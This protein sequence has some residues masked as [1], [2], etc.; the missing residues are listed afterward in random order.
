ME[1]QFNVASD[2]YLAGR[3][4]D[5]ENFTAEVYYV[6]AEDERGNRWSHFSRFAGA[7]ASRDEDGFWHF[8]DVREAA[9][10]EAERLL[11]RVEAAGSPL[12]FDHWFG[13][14][15]AYGSFAYAAYGAADDLAAER[16][17]RF[18]QTGFI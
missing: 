4:E 12:N 2:I 16:A 1:Y 9:R 18:D 11:A 10:A 8:A 13:M 14:A 15:P 5:G 6:V 17:E 7:E 3:T